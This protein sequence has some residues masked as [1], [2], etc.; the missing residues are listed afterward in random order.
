MTEPRMVH[1]RAAGEKSRGGLQALAVQC[2]ACGVVLLIVLALKLTGS[3]LYDR[4]KEQ[5]FE[6]V[7]ENSIADVLADWLGEDAA[8]PPAETQAV[9]IPDDVTLAPLP[10]SQTAAVPLIGG[11]VTSAFGIRTEPLRDGTGFHR[12]VDVSAK[13]GTALYALYDGTVERVATE[14]S[15]GKYIVIQYGDGLQ[16]LYAHCEKI[17]AKEGACVTAGESVATVGSTG[18]ST[19]NHVHIMVRHHGVIYNP[20]PLLPAAWYA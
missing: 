14:Q 16:V 17:I 6:G 20:A 3:G 7:T 10:L 5:F 2:I 13:G 8:T 15:Y 4:L 19:G 18:E 9:S 1:R 11:T 12:G